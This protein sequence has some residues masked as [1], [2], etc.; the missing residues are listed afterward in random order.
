MQLTEPK[1][2]LMDDPGYRGWVT[3]NPGGY[4]VNYMGGPRL[5]EPVLHRAGC[6]A[7]DGT[8]AEQVAWTGTWLKAC[9][10]DRDG[11]V[12]WVRSQGGED[13]RH[14]RICNP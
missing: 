5:F 8:P 6:P 2:F 3:D 7:V 1:Q 12:D 14:C 10:T 9:S 11:L 13:L 4:V